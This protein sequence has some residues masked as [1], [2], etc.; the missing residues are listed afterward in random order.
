MSAL[1]KRVL[2]AHPLEI[3]IDQEIIVPDIKD[4][5]KIEKMLEEIGETELEI[6]EAGEKGIGEEKEIEQESCGR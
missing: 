4:I 6:G 5:E 3:N 1:G 2:I